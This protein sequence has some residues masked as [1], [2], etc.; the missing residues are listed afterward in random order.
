MSRLPKWSL[1]EF[2][3]DH[4]WWIVILTV[5]LSALALTQFPKAT[6]DTNPKHMLP[7]TSDV[8]VW[9]DQVEDN[10]DLYEDMVV[11]GVV[12]EQGVLNPQTL[13]RIS[14]ITSAVLEIEGVAARDV[15]SLSTVDD[16]T[17]EGGMLDVG[18]LMPEIPR[19][20]EELAQLERA[21]FRNPL[22]L[23]RV[24]S[25]DKKATAIYVPL[26]AGVNGKAVAD[27]IREILRGESGPEQFY[28]AGDPVARDTFGSEMFKLMAIFA[29][30]AGLLMFLARYLMFRD[31]F[32]SIALMMDAMVAIVWSMGL[33]IAL[34]FPIHIMSSMAPVFL[35]AIATDSIHIFNEFYFRFRESGDR[36]RA[37]LETMQAVGRPVRYT[38]YAT[39]AGFAVLLFMHIEP[40]RVFGGLVA[41]GTLCLRILSFSFIPAMFTFVKDDT[42]RRTAERENA[43]SSRTSRLLARAALVG[44]AHPGRSVLVGLLVLAVA[45]F[46]MTRIH[47][48]NNIVEWFKGNSEIATADRV[49]NTALGGTSPAYIVAIGDG[50][51]RIKDPAS[52]RTIEELQRRLES[53][54]EVGKTTSVVDYVKRVNCV[55]HEEDPAYDAIPETK[56]MVGQYLFLFGMSAKPSDL[57]NVVDY[58]YRQANIFVQLKTWDAEAMRSVLQIVEEFEAEGDTGLSFKPA[59]TAYFN[60]VWNDEVL[61]DM[62]RGFVIALIV[63]FVILAAN[64]RSVKWALV[65]Y[66]PLVFTVFVIY[67]L[68]GLAGKDFDMPISVLSTLS[69]GMA[70]DF[71]IHFISRFRKR[72]AETH[73]AGSGLNRASLIETLQWT[74]A[75]PGK[76]IVRNALLFASAFSVMLFASLTPYVTVGAFIVSMMT[77]SAVTTILYLPAL[78][79]L[80]RGWLFQRGV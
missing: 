65:G 11:V 58:P 50:E 24:I 19:T 7:L 47:V 43:E 68:I 45:I 60:L 17:M 20:E 41:F 22:Y 75:R 30:I 62:I 46:G 74:A 71:S 42:L 9:N 23:N 37:I 2:S 3:V 73:P 15:S 66:A 40:V 54:P 21:L 76:G 4:P 12:H 79:V 8:R 67:G 78:V 49:L 31:L 59:G 25:A 1:V 64:F 26:E 39:M 10:F 6:T 27:R 55:L 29:P 18:P 53:L 72:I 38:A 28:V 13:E 61:G 48:N 77:L 32:L 35:M 69:L 34:G 52:L 51:D 14:R 16:V 5:L 70:V 63:V 44:A 33:L 56:E 36:R 80:L 57:N